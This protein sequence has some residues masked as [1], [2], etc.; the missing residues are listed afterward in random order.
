MNQIFETLTL[1]MYTVVVD[2]GAC[3]Q[4]QSVRTNTHMNDVYVQSVCQ[5]RAHK[6]AKAH[7]RDVAI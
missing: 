6:H 5:D 3:V 2:T 1:R 7:A 4:T